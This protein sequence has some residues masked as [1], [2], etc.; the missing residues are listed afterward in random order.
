MALPGPGGWGLTRGLRT[1]SEVLSF[2]VIAC[3]AHDHAL[4]FSSREWV[5]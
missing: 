5:R 3:C 1:I 2:Q 4:D